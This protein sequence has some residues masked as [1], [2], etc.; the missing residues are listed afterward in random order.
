MQTEMR[1]VSNDLNKWG[2]VVIATLD[3]YPISEGNKKLIRNFQ[4]YLFSAG[5][6]E[7]RI[8]KVVN[9][10]K[11]MLLFEEDNLKV[12][13]C[14]LDKATKQDVLNLVAH[15]N[16]IPVYSEATKS[17]YRRCIKQFYKW[18]KEEDER[19][20]SKDDKTRIEAYKFYNYIE[21][22]V[23]RAYKKKQIDPSDVLTDED[24]DNVVRKGCRTIKEKTLIKFLHETGLR[25]GELLNLR[26][27]HIE[28]KKNIGIA[29]VDGKTGR[30]AVQFTNSMAYVVQWLNV[31]PLNDV[32][33]A[34]LW[35]G[36]SPN[37]LYEPMA[38]RGIVKLIDR[39]FRR[40]GVK[41]R[42]NPHWFRHSRASLLAPKLTESL[43]CKY[44][45][46]SI[47]SDQPKTYLHLCPQQLE[48]AFL[49]I[50]GLA[51]EEEK[52]DLPQRC[53]CGAVNDSFARYCLQCGN[54][55][56]V[57]TAIQD[58]EITKTETGKA[59]KEMMEMC[60]NPEMLKAFMEFKEKFKT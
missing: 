23:K 39:C 12:F 43:L 57:E 55:L 42:H 15:I 28:I 5:S 4:N 19:L 45:G 54:P 51:E 21:K 20:Y 14:D 30:R 53:G 33:D 10:L 6:G 46:W 11:K 25:V 7:G 26:V 27:K 60:K 22:E 56:R 40:A 31:H 38:Y 41:K 13:D 24:I 9:Q 52:K 3:K 49:K 37:R 1:I 44:F 59:L 50:N 8:G 47:G 35:L 48:D 2:R 58:Q 16:R 32:P 34:F 36:E 18:L 29:H 17:D